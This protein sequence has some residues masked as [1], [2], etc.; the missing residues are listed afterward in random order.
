M[1]TLDNEKLNLLVS[2]QKEME[3]LLF[4]VRAFTLINLYRTLVLNMYL[5]MRN[6]KIFK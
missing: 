6:D 2:L 5:T 3:D 4:D 1:K